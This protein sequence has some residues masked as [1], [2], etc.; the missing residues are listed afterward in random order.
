MT[1]YIFSWLFDSSL[2][3]LEQIRTGNPIIFL[4]NAMEIPWPE[5]VQNPCHV[6]AWK[7]NI[8]WINDMV[9]WWNLVWIWTKLIPSICD[10]VQWLGISMRIL[11]TF[12]TGLVCFLLQ[13]CDAGSVLTTHHKIHHP[14]ASTVNIN[15]QWSM[16]I[17]T[18]NKNCVGIQNRKH[19]ELLLIKKL[20]TVG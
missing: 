15:S 19:E 13:F 17:W 20:E 6:P 8:A 5:L 12:F 11:V 10:D 14:S 2:V 16:E 9:W 7:T 1:L 4:A 3:W 18:C